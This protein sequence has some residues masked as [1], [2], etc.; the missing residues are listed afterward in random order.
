[1]S[2][3][4]A[5]ISATLK[6]ERSMKMGIFFLFLAVAIVFFFI[7]NSNVTSDMTTTFG[8]NRGKAAIELPP[9][10]LPTQMTL[11]AVAILI[12]FIGGWQL[13]K[14]F[15]NVN[16]MLLA[17]CLL[18][19]FAFL[20]WAARGKSMN[21]VGMLYESLTR[22]TP[23]AFGALSGILCERAGVVNIAIEGMML[24]GAMVSV[25]VASILRNHDAVHPETGEMLYP[26]WLSSIGSTLEMM[27]I[28]DALPWHLMIGLL[29]G[30]FIG[31]LLAAFHA[32]LSIEYKVDQIISGT[33]INIFSLGMTSF[34]SQR[35]LQPLQAL[36][37][38]GTFKPMP[39]P[40][41]SNIPIIGPLLFERP[42]LVYVLFALVIGIHVMLFYTRWGLRTIAVGEHPKAADT[43]GINVFRMRYINVIVGGMVAGLGGAYFTLGSVG[44]FDENLTAGKG[45][46]GLA[47]MIFGKWTALGAFGASLIFGFADALQQ[48]LQ[49]FSSQVPIPSEFLLMGP[50]IITIIILAGVIGRA[51]PPAADGIPYEK[52]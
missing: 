10:E 33:V 40:G 7:F 39:I 23:I 41:L 34:L 31:G 43:L 6:E 37:S 19:V 14:G 16:G 44:R 9:L 27:N 17:A 5:T 29:G 1:M 46:I 8:L 45:F 36:N 35:F 28:S 50:Y 4:T 3:M 42:F 18:F 30:I 48:K 47:A 11:W 12:G 49:I 32:W 21:M 51:I 52:E 20:T 22:A 13:S 26:A 25:V 15:K 2:S 38:S 24:S